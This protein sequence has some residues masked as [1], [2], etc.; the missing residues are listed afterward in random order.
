M[1][2]SWVRLRVFVYLVRTYDVVVLSSC[3]YGSFMCNSCLCA[4]CVY[5]KPTA[6]HTEHL[7]A[8]SPIEPSHVTPRTN[9]QDRSGHVLLQSTRPDKQRKLDQMK[10]GFSLF[11]IINELHS[12]E[13]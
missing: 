1:T 6:F 3:H 7:G 2:S 8:A 11:S 13:A 10:Q 4:M 9:K 5:M 12:A